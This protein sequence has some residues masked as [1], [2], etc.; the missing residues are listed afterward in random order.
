[1]TAWF[2]PVIPSGLV[3]SLVV[4]KLVSKIPASWIMVLG[5]ISYLVGSILAAARPPTSIYWTYYFFSVLIITIGMDTSF[6]SAAMI[7]AGAVPQ[8]YQ[9]MAASIVMT[10][11]NYSISLGLGFA[12]MVEMNINN[13]GLTK[14]DKYKGYQGALWLSVCTISVSAELIVTLSSSL[15][16]SRMEPACNFAF[17]M[18]LTAQQT[19][20]PMGVLSTALAENDATLLFSGSCAHNTSPESSRTMIGTSNL[21]GKEEAPAE[22]AVVLMPDIERK[23]TMRSFLG[24]KEKTVCIRHMLMGPIRRSYSQR[25]LLSEGHIFPRRINGKQG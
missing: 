11:V 13:G 15:H 4:G 5:Q 20:L 2:I 23:D 25:K 12:G 9:G 18:P 6:P 8:K 22:T 14:A 10:V 17:D 1:M 3:S 24:K 19:D 16:T 7:F 21:K